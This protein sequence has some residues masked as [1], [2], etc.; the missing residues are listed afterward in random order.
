MPMQI[1]FCKSY[2][3]SPKRGPRMPDIVATRCV[4]FLSLDDHFWPRSRRN[5]GLRGP[6]QRKWQ[7]TRSFSQGGRKRIEYEGLW[8][9]CQHMA[10][11]RRL[12]LERKIRGPRIFRV[13]LLFYEISGSGSGLR[14]SRSDGYRS[15]QPLVLNPS[16]CFWGVGSRDLSKARRGHT[17]G[18]TGSR[19]ATSKPPTVDTSRSCCLLQ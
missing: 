18:A 11:K 13:K 8:I 3:T 17:P 6:L 4:I 19:K 7:I 10:H 15:N 1:S 2:R 12:R 16:E 14:G 9:S 5:R